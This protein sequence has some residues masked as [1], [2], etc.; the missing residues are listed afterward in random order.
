MVAFAISV[1]IRLKRRMSLNMRK[2]RGLNRFLRWANTLL[3][4]EPLHSSCWPPARGTCTE[5]DM[6][7]LAVSTSRSANNLIKFG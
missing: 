6:S 2:N 1:V 3:N 5:N 4:D 7:D